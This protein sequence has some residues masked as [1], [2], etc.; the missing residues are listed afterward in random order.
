VIIST[1]I[2]IAAEYLDSLPSYFV[3]NTSIGKRDGAIMDLS[4]HVNSH[5][6]TFYLVRLVHTIQ[7]NTHFR[8]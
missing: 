2:E 5:C 1:F 8:A 4:I 7:V 3:E 6:S